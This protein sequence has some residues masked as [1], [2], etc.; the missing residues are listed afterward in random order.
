MIRDPYKKLAKFYDTFVEP[1]NTVLRK[2]VL[3]MYPPKEGMRVL[4]VGCGTGTNL[5]LYHQAGCNVYGIDL[6]SSMLE[7][8][9]RKLGE[10]ADLRMG[11]A[12]QMPYS[13]GFFDVVIAMLTLHEMPRQVRLPVMDEMVRVM[14]QDGHLLLIDFHPGP[15][16]FPMG[17]LYKTIILFFEITA[18]REHFRNYRDFIAGKGLPSLIETN[19]LSIE[20]EK[21]VSGG[22]LVL[23]SAKSN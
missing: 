1:S 7:V 15:I 19:S 14:K 8:A 13:D 6:S 22:N 16:R 2:I 12:S 21:I 18:G 10:Q 4:E 23:Y 9:R 17:W 3:K 11:D 20:K 5:K